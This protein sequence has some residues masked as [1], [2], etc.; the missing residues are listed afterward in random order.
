MKD[1]IKGL[2]GA[3]SC[4]RSLDRW[5]EDFCKDPKIQQQVIQHF[6]KLLRFYN[7]F[8]VE[9]LVATACKILSDKKVTLPPVFL[10]VDEYQDLNKKDQEMVRLISSKPGSQIVVVGDDAQ[11]IY[12]F[13]HANYS[14]IREI[15]D[16]PQW[17]HVMFAKSH[18]LPPPIL[19]ASQAL[20]AKEDYLGGKMDVPKDNKE[21]V[22]TLQCTKSD[23]QLQL[24]S[25]F[26]NKM[27]KGECTDNKGKALCYKDFMILCP[28]KNFIN[29]TIACL[30]ND[31]IPTKQRQK[32]EIPNE[33]WHLLLVF[34][35][36]HSEDRLALRQWL[37]VCGIAPDR[38][39]AIRKAA[40]AAG[41]SLF[42]FC[43]TLK[44]PII[45]QIYAGLETLEH[46]QNDIK[47]FKDALKAFPY[48][49]AN[50][51]L[52]S[53][54]GLPVHKKDGDKQPVKV[55][56]IIHSLYEEYGLMDQGGNTDVS[57]EDKVLITTMHSAKGLESKIVFIPWLN[58]RFMP[59]SGRD[60]KEERRVL[61]VALTRAKE[62]LIL[63]FDEI[64]TCRGKSMSPFLEEIKDYLD[65]RRVN[66]AGL[67]KFKN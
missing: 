6:E 58:C 25:A 36:L 41:Q 42:K 31:G 7:T 19:R 56:E 30:N 52:F 20:I 45:K 44:N 9:G 66:K 60:K 51:S 39:T 14:G 40:M 24:I 49:V 3:I 34:R 1:N 32:G 53:N 18:R 2:E 59:G 50:D 35:M 22:L 43:A 46:A 5:P 62:N 55:A 33:L 13:R 23:L 37:E 57:N 67:E 15:W 54:I 65:V 21:K 16:D 17:E 38:I 4:C 11:S 26:I 28:T 10:Q 8:D 27:M 63:L 47:K 48:L 64:Y 61:Y 12:G 29:T